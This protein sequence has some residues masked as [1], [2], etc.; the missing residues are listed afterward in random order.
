MS[1]HK[2]FK[3]EMFSGRRYSLSEGEEIVIRSARFTDAPQIAGFLKSIQITPENLKMKLSRNNIEGF[4]KKGGFFKIWNA[5]E[6]SCLMQDA[7]NLILL[8]VVNYKGQETICGFL[9]CRLVLDSIAVSDWKLDK[10]ILSAGQV[11][12]YNTALEKNLIFTAVECAVHPNGHGLGIS[13]CIIYEMYNWLLQRGF[14]FSVLQVYRILGEYKEGCFVKGE[15]P[16]EA[17]IN[18]IKKYGAVCIKKT[19]IPDQIVG[20]RRIKVSADVFLLD[21]EY[22]VKRLEEFTSIFAP[23]KQVRSGTGGHI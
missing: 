1:L 14:L 23:G 2:A 10:E 11:T 13:Y 21:L 6:L 15:L 17:S 9:W 12:K 8:A 22:A 18:H 7:R 19:S 16:N 3:D 20:T 4:R 5:E